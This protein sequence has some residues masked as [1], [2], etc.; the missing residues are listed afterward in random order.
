MTLSFLDFL[1]ERASAG[2]R[3][4]NERA[5]HGKQEG[6]KKSITKHETGALGERIVMHHLKATGHKDVHALNTEH[7]NYPVDLATRHH[8]IEVKT[9]HTSNHKDMHKWRATIGQPGKKETEWLKKASP[10][11]KSKWNKRKAKAIMERKNKALN[12]HSKK[13]GI[14][15]TGK[16]YGVILH[17][18]KKIADVHE[19]NGFHH[20]INWRHPDTTKA[21]VGSYKYD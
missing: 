11:A 19:F 2:I 3:P 17:H 14:K 18:D 6:G 16:T 21:H 13:H 4:T 5:Y 9:G 8:L 15:M 20:S 12:D 7:S 10:E 1:I